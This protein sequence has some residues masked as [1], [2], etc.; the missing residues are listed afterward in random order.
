MRSVGLRAGCASPLLLPKTPQPAKPGSFPFLRGQMRC[1]V[2][3]APGP[4]GLLQ[5]RAGG[6]GIGELGNMQKSGKW[7]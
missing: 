7:L 1:T 2:F 3:P 4:G 5:Q 6:D